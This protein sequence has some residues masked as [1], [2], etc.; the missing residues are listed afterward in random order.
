MSTLLKS[1]L[2]GALLTVVAITNASQATAATI[3]GTLTADNHYG[4]YTGNKDGS[5]LNFI[6][7]NEKGPN[8]STGGY[9]WSA[10]ETWKFDINP[11]DY[12]YTVV[13]DDAA[14]AES[15]IG[16]FTLPD[17]S[18]L[19][20]N[21]KDWEYVISNGKNPGDY[22]D[23]PLLSELQTEIKNANWIASTAVGFNGIQPWGTIQGV[24]ANAQFLNVSNPNSQN[25]T[26]FRTQAPALAASVPEPASALGL[27]A[28][29]AIATGSVMK[30]KF[31]TIP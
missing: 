9:N 28:F 23:V 4:L 31:K 12:I 20:S 11:G 30:R 3:T 2:T 16:E 26:I 7:R 21:P 13:W 25:Y 29:G 18:K 24:S 27:L 15:W 17:G 22:G 1:L 8:G 6:G 14:V 19:L 10:A 5:L